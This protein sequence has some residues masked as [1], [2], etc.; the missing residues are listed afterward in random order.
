MALAKPLQPILLKLALINIWNNAQCIFMIHFAEHRTVLY[1]A[2]QGPISRVHF[3]IGLHTYALGQR[4]VGY[5]THISLVIHQFNRAKNAV[6]YHFLG[7]GGS[8]Q[9]FGTKGL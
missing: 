6:A 8:T 1:Q 9:A 3:V 5:G 2:V 7:N 4:T